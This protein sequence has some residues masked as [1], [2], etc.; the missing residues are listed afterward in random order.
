MAVSSNIDVTLSTHVNPSFAN[1]PINVYGIGYGTPTPTTT[2]IATG[3]TNTSGN[4]STTVTVLSGAY[5]G[6]YTQAVATSASI[7]L[8]GTSNTVV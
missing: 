2:L 1:I 6:Y 8:T 4:F 5:T 3:V 7:Y